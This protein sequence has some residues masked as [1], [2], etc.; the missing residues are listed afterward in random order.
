MATSA[1]TTD[2]FPYQGSDEPLLH[3]G[4]LSVARRRFPGAAEPFIDLSTGIN[5]HP[6]PVPRLPAEVFSRLPDPAAIAALTAA[7]ATAYGAPSPAHVVAAP[8]TQ[9]LLPVVAALARRG[10]AFIISP[11]YGEHARAAALAGHGVTPVREIGACGDADLVIVTNPNSPDGRMYDSEALLALAGRLRAR[12]GT[13]I[14]DEAFMDVAPAGAS[15]AAATS[16][17]NVIVLRSFG[18]FFGLGGLRLGFAIL[19]P[20]SAARLAAQLGPWA[21]SGPALAVGLKALADAGW[22]E[23]TRRRLAE[24][25]RRLDAILTDAGL[26][27][28]GGTALFRLAQTRAAGELFDHL[29]CAGILAR[30]FPD[31]PNWLRFGLPADPHGW[32]RLQIAMAGFHGSR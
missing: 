26:D 31:Q 21:V 19:E 8:G 20:G 10:R 9:I 1:S 13:L 24:D 25:T 32:R 7:A 4:A 14:V 30:I 22:I 23:R 28:A 16:R 18:K 29:G 3:G 12:G 17:G 2:V 6:Y 15:L 27:I 11:T 5:P